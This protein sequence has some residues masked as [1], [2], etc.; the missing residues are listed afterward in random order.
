MRPARTTTDASARLNRGLIGP[1]IRK[2]GPETGG[3][4]RPDPPCESLVRAMTI[5]NLQPDA[6]GLVRSG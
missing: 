6:T 5:R 3:S 1:E 4:D 2:V